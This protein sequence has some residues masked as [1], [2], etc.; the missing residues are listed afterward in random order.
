MALQ[1][2]PIDPV[3]VETARVARA[4]FRKGNLYLRIRDALGSLYVDEQFA[5]LF[6]RRGQPAQA[7]PGVSLWCVSFNFW[8]ISRI[9]KQPMQSAVASTGNMH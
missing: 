7:R 1:S 8:K 9:G 4:A 2:H 6:A 3:P 5:D